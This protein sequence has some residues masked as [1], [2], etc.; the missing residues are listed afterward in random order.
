MMLALP[1]N[2]NKALGFYQLSVVALVCNPSKQEAGTKESKVQGY[3]WL[4]RKLEAGLEYKRP[5]LK[6]DG[7]AGSHKQCAQLLV[8]FP[9]PMWWFTVACNS[10]SNAIFWPL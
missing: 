2:T 6:T 5:A 3:P 4:H 9:A 7:T 8:P 10:S 1:S